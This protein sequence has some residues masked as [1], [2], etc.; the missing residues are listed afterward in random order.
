MSV[1]AV[2]LRLIDVE[3]MKNPEIK[4]KTEESNMVEHPEMAGFM[5]TKEEYKRLEE[6]PE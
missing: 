3:L 6:N 5:I 4:K 2:V 1:T